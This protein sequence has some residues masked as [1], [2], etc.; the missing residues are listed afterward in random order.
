MPEEDEL[1]KT[2]TTAV[3]TVLARLSAVGSWFGAVALGIFLSL[4]AGTMANTAADIPANTPANTVSGPS[5]VL[6]PFTATYAVS[7]R[8][9]EAGTLRMTLRHDAASDH[10]IFETSANPS[11]LA[12]LFIS[13]DATERSVLERT[14]D[15]VRP[16]SWEADDGKSGAKGDGKLQFNWQTNTVT[17]SFEGKPV[18]LPLTPG[19]MDRQSIQLG[20][21]AALL[22][23]REPGTIAMINGDSIRHYTYTRGKTATMDTKLGKLDTI[24]YESTRPN[25]NRVSRVWHAPSLEYVPV[26]A[27][28][29]R[30]GKV[31]T[32]MTLIALDK[33]DE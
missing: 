31:E 30:K 23:G 14:P 5:T 4:P 10:Y 28:Q 13:R 22:D 9:I 6:Q 2:V 32:V 26:R 19:V 27:E 16:L 15:G 17:G 3:A 8:G 33:S 1:P 24:V 18:S 12:R 20:A 21:M 25:S 29:V 11:A 7:F